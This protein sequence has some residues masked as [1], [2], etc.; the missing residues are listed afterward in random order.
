MES[1]PEINIEVEP[2]SLANQDFSGRTVIIDAGHGGSDTGFH[3]EG[4]PDE[5]H[6]NLEI[7]RHL[8]I[9]LG[10][11]GFKTLLTRNSDVEMS[12]DQR[13]GIANRHGG[14]LYISLHLGGSA[15]KSKAGTA[16][17]SYG[18]AGTHVDEA[19]QGISYDAVYNEWLKGIRTDLNRFLASKI[20]ERLI[21]HLRVENRGVKELPLQ[22]LRFVMIPAVVVEAGMLSDATEG[23]NLISDNYR[24][25]IA[26]SIANAVVDFFNGIVIN[27]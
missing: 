6:I 10:K 1:A 4:R 18:K 21:K 19:A 8:A 20:N 9:C 22:P 24:K 16:C 25:A 15:D 3:Y 26:Q 12:H 13:L 14:D 27:Q 7:A 23:K 5:K 2:A 17:Y 11:A